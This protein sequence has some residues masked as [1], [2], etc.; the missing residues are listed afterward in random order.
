MHSRVDIML[1]ATLEEEE[2]LDIVEAVRSRIGE[3]EALGNCFNPASEL[4]LYNSGTLV[5]SDLSS[6]L[7][8]ILTACEDWKQKTGGLFDVSVEGKV[9]LSGFLK[10]YALDEVRLVIEKG[11]IGK[12]LVSLGNSSVMALGEP[13]EG[14]GGW[15]VEN[16]NGEKFTLRNECLTTS[17][18]DSEER[19]HIINPLT[20]RFVE[21]KRL[22]SV[23]T[24]S[25]AEG[26][27]MSTVTFIRSFSS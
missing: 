18:N 26:E 22:V 13:N 25:G 10:G 16:G 14:C 7:K 20:G 15:L 3:I 2:M 11:G 24:P 4:S 12:A 17:G 5:F 9:N 6:E 8:R 21:G 1:L 23:V 19:R 27:V